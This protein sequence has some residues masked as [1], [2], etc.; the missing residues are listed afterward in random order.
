[1]SKNNGKAAD[2]K[3]AADAQAEAPASAQLAAVIGDVNSAAKKLTAL[4][5]TLK[6]GL[7]HPLAN[8]AAAIQL[9]QQEQAEAA[10]A[11]SA[12]K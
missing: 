3:S 2:A 4:Q 9:L 12:T 1:M 10:Q 7:T 6:R 5:E 8:L 11:E